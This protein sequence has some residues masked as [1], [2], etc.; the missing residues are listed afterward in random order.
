PELV[1]P[2]EIV[3]FARARIETRLNGSIVQSAT[4]GEMI[5]PVADI[6]A[7]VSDFT[8][9]APGDVII[10]GTPGGVG[11]KR[12]PQLFMQAGD[13]VEVSIEGIGRLTNPIVSE[14]DPDRT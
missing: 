2:D 10:T 4:L 9:L 5:F 1:T 14:A 7:Y 6:I 12:E 3:E 8:P 13:T 11:F